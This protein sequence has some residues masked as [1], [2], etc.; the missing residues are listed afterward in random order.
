MAHPFGGKP[1]NL[2]KAKQWYQRLVSLYPNISWCANWI[3]E[4]ELFDDSDTSA[5]RAGFLRNSELCC[6]LNFIVLTGPEISEG[7]QFECGLFAVVN[8]ID[9]TGIGLEDV[10]RIDIAMKPLLA[11]VDSDAEAVQSRA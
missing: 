8:R 9:L 11:V 3:V 4:C 5:R 1:I 2:H 10:T 6:R 7:M